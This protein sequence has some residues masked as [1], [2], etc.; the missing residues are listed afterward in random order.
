MFEFGVNLIGNLFGHPSAQAQFK[1]IR[2]EPIS[3]LSVL[4][5]SINELKN[6]PSLLNTL[7]NWLAPNIL[8]SFSNR[9]EVS[10]SDSTCILKFFTCLNQADIKTEV[11]LTAFSTF[12]EA[13]KYECKFAVS[14]SYAKNNII[15][16]IFSGWLCDTV[17]AES[18]LLGHYLA[19]NS[20][21]FCNLSLDQSLRIHILDRLLLYFDQA[22]SKR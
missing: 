1:I 8:E 19:M 20:A 4:S 16:G 5:S 17:S 11:S 13:A 2:D 21:P 12:F 15:K 6:E 7:Q 14:A 18:R 3:L 10:E 22:Q 9:S